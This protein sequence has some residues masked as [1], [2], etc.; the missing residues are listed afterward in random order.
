MAQHPG[1]P[2][3]Q[4][5]R[6]RWPISTAYY[7]GTYLWPWEFT[8]VARKY[9]RYNEDRYVTDPFEICRTPFSSF[10]LAHDNSSRAPSG[11]G[12]RLGE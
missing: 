1:L 11:S 8:I 7:F 5:W 3:R 12:R 10:S 2:D 4:M 9:L 6:R